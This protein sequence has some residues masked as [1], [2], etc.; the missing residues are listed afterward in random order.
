MSAPGGP[1]H[2][3]SSHLEV[4]MPNNRNQDAPSLRG[5]LTPER[6]AEALDRSEITL[7]NWR[8]MG[9]GP[10]YH[11]DPTGRV[12]YLPADVEVWRAGERVE[13]AHG[14]AGAAAAA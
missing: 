3:A 13:P 1:L 4:R 14:H 6:A 9:V 5:W 8:S 11:R 2:C 7:R 12:W 10:A